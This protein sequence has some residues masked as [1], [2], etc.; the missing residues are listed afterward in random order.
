MCDRTVIDRH[1]HYHTWETEEVDESFRFAI[2]FT[3]ELWNEIRTQVP[4]ASTEVFPHFI[5]KHY[6]MLLYHW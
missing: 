3:F 1:D 5:W 4:C 6:I 2:A